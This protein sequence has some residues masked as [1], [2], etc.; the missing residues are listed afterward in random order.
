MEREEGFVDES[1]N[2]AKGEIINLVEDAF[3]EGWTKRGQQLKVIASGETGFSLYRK[4]YQ[5]SV[6]KRTLDK[7]LDD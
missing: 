4:K 1:V 3:L 6:T 7:I 5:E 2:L